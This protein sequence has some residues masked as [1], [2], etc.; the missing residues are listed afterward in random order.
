MKKITLPSTL[1][2]ECWF[3]EAN[4]E[5]CDPHLGK[6]YISYSSISSWEEYKA[7]FIKQKF[8]G[9][10]LPDGIYAKFGSY[11]GQALEH[12]VFPD[13][14]PDNFAGQENMDLIKLRPPGTIYEKMI[15]IDMGDYV[16]IGFIDVYYPMPN[17]SVFIRDQKTGGK[18]KEHTYSDSN[19]IQT[20][21]Y[22]HATELTGKAIHSTDVWFIRRTGSHMKPPLT[23][24]SE[25][26][27]IKLDYNPKRVKYALEKVDRVVR[28][29]S[30]LY[31]IYL[32]YF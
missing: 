11:C 9:I 6:F 7:D 10:K 4:K 14:N 27:S 15:L 18:D 30:E 19:Y 20:V 16:I 13:E 17:G 2:K 24:S 5:L 22:A 26:F 25:Q 29:I 23:I 31:E 21:L 28:E 3:Y 8:V 1:T 12:G 32:K